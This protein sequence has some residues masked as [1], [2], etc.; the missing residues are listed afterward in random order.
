MSHLTK[1]V[2]N[3]LIVTRRSINYKMKG[4]ERLATSLNDIQA[5]NQYSTISG[6]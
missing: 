6:L 4:T 1:Y 3:K 2:N 5:D